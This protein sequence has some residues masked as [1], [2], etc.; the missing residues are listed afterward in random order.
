VRQVL[1]QV[2]R[3]QPVSDVAKKL[4]NIRA[5]ARHEYPVGDIE[6]MLAEIEGG[7]EAAP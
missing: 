4:E 1:A 3:E 5:A 7:L 2:R 6:D